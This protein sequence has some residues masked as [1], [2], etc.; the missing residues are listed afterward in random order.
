MVRG[1]DIAVAKLT[2]NLAHQVGLNLPEIRHWKADGTIDFV[3][4]RLLSAQLEAS[5][6]PLCSSGSAIGLI[7]RS[8][9]RVQRPKH[10]NCQTI[11][12][13]KL[14]DIGGLNPLRVPHS[15]AS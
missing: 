6:L 13:F 10:S 8:Q 9:P 7:A 11:A 4:S 5:L 12:A 3:S 15:E 14:D 1:L 2:E